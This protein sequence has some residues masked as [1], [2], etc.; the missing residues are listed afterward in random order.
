MYSPR[1]TDA[2][3][4]RTTFLVPDAEAAANFYVEVF[5][6][7][8]WY[9]QE[10]SV[11]GRFP[12]A[13]PHGARAHLVLIK[14]EDP[15]IGMLGLMQYLEPPF[16]TAVKTGRTRVSMGEAIL[17]V[18]A[19]DLDGIHERARAR[20]ATIVTAPVDWEVPRNDGQGVFRLR[21][22]SL[23]DPNGIYIEVNAFR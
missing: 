17:V 18:E 9:D 15:H 8:R 16:D 11:D 1:M 20:G 4:R 21:T 3:L 7:T 12:P 23:F 6:W 22:L 2:I 19:K 5:G 14:A 13:A 10:L